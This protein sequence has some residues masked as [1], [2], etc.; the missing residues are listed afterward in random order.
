MPIGLADK[1]VALLTSLT[2]QQIEELP[3]A[4]RRRLEH[5]C[6]RVAVL[7]APIAKELPKSGVLAALRDGKRSD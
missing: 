6:L 4:E 2:D 3:P 1:I 7:C 5:M